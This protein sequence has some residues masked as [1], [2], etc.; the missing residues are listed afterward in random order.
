MTQEEIDFKLQKQIALQI[1]EI[2]ASRF[3]FKKHFAWMNPIRKNYYDVNLISEPDAYIKLA[4]VEVALNGFA[5]GLK[6]AGVG[7]ITFNIIVN[8]PLTKHERRS[9]DSFLTSFSSRSEK[10]DK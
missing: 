7:K 2:L 9:M 4:K 8:K 6:K 1:K 10:D 3:G 5:A